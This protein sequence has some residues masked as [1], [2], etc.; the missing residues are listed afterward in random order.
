MPL[1]EGLLNPIST[2]SPS[3]VDVRYDSKL[4]IYD[5]IKEARREDD[6]LNQGEWQQ[7]RKVADLPF[8]LKTTQEALATKT[9]D[10]QLAAW[11]CD[12][13]LRTEGFGGL[14]QGLSL[15]Q[16]FI[17]N[18]WDT[19]FPPIEDGDLE[20][21]AAPLDWLGTALDIP[22]KNVPLTRTAHGFFKYKESRLVGYDVPTL[23]DKERDQRTQRINE[24]KL[25]AEDFDKAFNETPKAFYVQAEKDLDGCLSVLNS[26]DEACDEKFG[27]AG[28]ALG[29]LKTALEEIRHTVHG[30]LQKKRETEPDP[31]EDAGSVAESGVNGSAIN[32][33]GTPGAVRS[34]IP[35]IVISIMTSSEPADR[36]EMIANVAKAAAF[37]RQREPHSPAPYLMMRGL[38]W[39][40]LRA[41][42][43]LSDAALL[44]APPTELRQQIKRLALAEKWPE[45]LETA[46]NAMSLPCS[47][48]WLDLQRHVVEACAAMGT[49]Y[50]PI[51]AA[52]RLELK[53]LLHDVPELLDASMLDDTPAANAETRAWLLQ[54]MRPA[55]KSLQAPEGDAPTDAAAEPATSQPE[56]APE[57]SWPSKSA[58]SYALATEALKAGQAEKAFSIM[59]EEV[60]RQTSGRGRFQRKLQLVELCAAAGKD[61]IAQPLLDDLAGAIENHKLDEW[62]DRQM[63]AAALITL[64]NLSRRIQDDSSEKQKIF[65]RICRLDP[66]RALSAG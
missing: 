66:V 48:A 26:L 57:P 44:E 37:L 35:S 23:G 53:V 4:L 22:L 56:S 6:G 27:N 8:V 2:E 16:G 40:E 14:Q 36:R 47:R 18:F 62:E 3:G 34:A 33:S 61:A 20:L 12:A 10:L 7:E 15:C 5:K 32:A 46:E 52:I 51:A 9:K 30:L 19:L 65:E 50:E 38:R 41:A 29:K 11:L 31:V 17:A 63:M 42:A 24:G 58:D 13:L 43:R 55:S 25:S 21:R 28:P 1:R 59:Q 39:G 45:L 49:D 54:L 64:M 60:A